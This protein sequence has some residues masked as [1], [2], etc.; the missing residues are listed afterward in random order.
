MASPGPESLKSVHSRCWPR[1]TS[2]EGLMGLEDLPPC[3]V[4]WLLAGG[5]WFLTTWGSPYGCLQHGSWLS[6]KLVIRERRKKDKTEA[7]VFVD[8]SVSAVTFST[9][10]VFCWP[11]GPT[12]VQY[13]RSLCMVMNIRGGCSLGDSLEACHHSLPSKY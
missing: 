4:T 10:T 2:P 6:P 3:S 13:G 11:H 1:G 9:P 12:L 5:S 7:A 8:N